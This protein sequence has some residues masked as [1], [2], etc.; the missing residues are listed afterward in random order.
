MKSIAEAKAEVKADKDLLP[1]TL[2]AEAEA[3]E[4][5]LKIPEKALA[6]R[7]LVSERLEEK[8]LLPKNLPL[9][10]AL[11]QAN[12][13]LLPQKNQIREERHPARV[14][15]QEEETKF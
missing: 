5:E 3:P 1:E 12:L 13:D 6:E 8:L 10:E 14:L 11:P 9:P 4:A 7:L 2:E 15:L